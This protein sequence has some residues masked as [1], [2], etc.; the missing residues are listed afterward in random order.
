MKKSTNNRSR[1]TKR[2]ATS[3]RRVSPKAFADLKSELRE[4]QETLQAIRSG[5]V[6]ALVVDGPRGNQI[7]SLSGADQPYRVYLERMQ[8]GAVTIAPDGL[9]LFANQRFAE[10]VDASLER[11]ISANARDFLDPTAWKKISDVLTNDDQVVK[12]ESLLRPN[13]KPPLSVNLTASRLPLAGQNVLCLVVTDISFLKQNEQLRLAKEVAEKANIAKDSFLAVLSHELRTP[14]N[15]VLLIASEAAENRDLPPGIRS[16]FET[17]RRNVELEA[18]LIDDLLDLTRISTGKLKLDK[19]DINIH[20][21]LKSTIAMIQNDIQEKEIVLE[22]KFDAFQNI[23]C[24]DTVRLQQ[25]FWNVLKNAVKFTPCRGTIRIETRSSREQYIVTISDTGIGMTP[26][27]LERIFTAF[28]QGDHS[29]DIRR[30]GGL[31]LGL[32]ITQKLVELHFGS[33][34][35]TSAGRDRGSTFTI[36]FPLADWSKPPTKHPVA[37]E[38]ENGV[39]LASLRIL[40]IEDHEPTRNAMAMILT[41]RSHKVAMAVSS[42]E[43]LALVGENNFDIVVSDIG[44]PDGSGYDLFKKLRK[45][46]PHLKGIALTGYGTECDR[47]RSRDCGF[48]AHLTKPVRMQELESALRI[49]MADGADH[50][51]P[52]RP[53][54]TPLHPP[55]TTASVR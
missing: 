24:G 32:A 39:N 4:A 46:S 48:H 49:A 8:E 25:I 45:Q 9:V 43:A 28:I 2:P 55:A 20:A 17:I 27:E 44:L 37:A 53:P 52:T 10:M 33:I 16:R 34:E 14:L 7:Y 42:R 12:C 1:P 51:V 38:P 15:P 35:A 6:D 26:P 11:V 30:F 18:R 22:Q 19:R 40:L 3:G 47:S 29:E 36:R 5:E 50:A 23:V 31:G 54:L 21:A 13:G 41:R